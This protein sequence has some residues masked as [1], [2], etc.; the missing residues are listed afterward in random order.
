MKPKLLFITAALAIAFLLAF[1]LNE[2]NNTIPVELKK[3]GIVKRN[4]IS[5]S[6]DWEKLKDWMEETDIPPMPGAGTYEW[7]YM[8]CR[9]LCPVA[10]RNSTHNTALC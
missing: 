8:E 7:K 5:C 9:D 6:P 4:I 1:S 2:N 10:W 3:D